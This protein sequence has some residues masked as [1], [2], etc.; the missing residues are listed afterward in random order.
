M[1]PIVP[2]FHVNAWGLPFMATMVGAKQVFPGPHLDAKS[3]LELFQ[4]ERVT[5]TAG[6]PTV[7]LGILDELDKNPKAW[8]TSSLKAMIVGGAAAPK[9]M[10]E[11]FEKRHGLRAIA[12]LHAVRGNI[13]TKA[14]DVPEVLLIDL[15]SL[16]CRDLFSAIAISPFEFWGGII[17]EGAAWPGGTATFAVTGRTTS[18]AGAAWGV[19]LDLPCRA[20]SVPE[21]GVAL[22]SLWLAELRPG[23]WRPL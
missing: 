3:L 12:P 14:R 9:A 16:S 1:L 6:V 20:I 4:S 15:A 13:D 11:G 5:F 21:T 17:G 10:I 22:P 8:D 7:W 2:M 23:V 19:S 18:E